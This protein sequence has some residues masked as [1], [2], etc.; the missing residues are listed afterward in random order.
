MDIDITAIEH[1]FRQAE[2][3]TLLEHEVYAVLNALGMDTPDHIFL[4]VG[5]EVTGQDLAG[6]PGRSLVLKVVS[7]GILHKSD[8]GGVRFVDK[9]P[10]AVNRTVADMLEKIPERFRLWQQEFHPGGK[11][12]VSEDSAALIQG[13]LVLEAVDYEKSGFGSELLLG[14]RNSREFGPIVSMGSGGLDVEYLNARIKEGRSVSIS[15]AHLTEGKD[16][17]RILRP[18]AFYDKLTAGFRGLPPLVAEKKLAELFLK[19]QRLGAHFSPYSQDSE[20]VIEEAEINPFVISRGRLLPL[21]GLCRIS[22]SKLRVPERPYA[23]IGFL[24][25]PRSIGIIGVSEKMNIGRIILNNILKQ[26]FPREKVYVVKPGVQEIEGCRCVPDVA[27]LPE[28]VDLFVHTVSAELGFQ[29]MRDLIQAQ[30]ARSVI[31]IA[32]GMGE[33]EGTEEI[34]RGIKILIRD[35]RAANQHVPVVNGGNCLGIFSRPG[36]YDTTFIPEH[37]IFSMPRGDM[38]PHPLV[39]LSQS[40]AYMI[41]RMSQIPGIEP[42]YAVSIGNQIDLTISDYLNYLKNR[43]E[44][45]IFALYIE[46]FLPGDGLALVRAAQEITRQPGKAIVAFKAGRSPEG[47]IASAS[48]T[49]SVAGDFEVSRA[50]LGQAGV[51]VSETIDEFENTTRGLCFLA[52]KKVRG[53]RVG[54]ISNA[55]F[56]CVIMSDSI[57]GEPALELARF[58]AATTER[59]AQALDPLGITR[60]Q[61]IRNPMDVTPAA[62]DRA[63]AA[64]VEAILED[65]N[66]DCA[67]VSP[68]PMSPAMNTLAPSEFHSEDLMREGSTPRRL[69][70]IFHRTEKPFV[71]SIDSGMPY[72]PMKE[73]LEGEGVPV[74]RRCDEAAAFLRRYVHH[75]LEKQA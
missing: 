14:L 15:S 16:V 22:R 36:K 38:R 12:D 62:D 56:E 73:L 52:D 50:L 48:H 75:F 53:N 41:S 63:F 33:K 4:P 23:D 49:A 26:G 59:M 72:Q 2:H 8:V 30:K 21:D 9:D 61:N 64:C 34:E 35:S 39:Y 10:E 71:V 66:V 55:G 7:H 27:G 45:R 29:V 6:I 65:E 54:L 37:K 18:L 13:T 51:I 5:Q 74:F 3:E 70:D 20:F 58:S 42:A 11:T 1:I 24:L 47:R 44:A 32:G 17:S 60:L 69:I 31:F 28:T 67:V 57:A 40:G 46:G 19:F 25:M 68:L 43:D